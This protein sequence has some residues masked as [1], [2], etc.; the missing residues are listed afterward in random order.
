MDRDI[1][2]Q[3][4]LL[5]LYELAPRQRTIRA[6][7]RFIFY[8]SVTLINIKDAHCNG[9]QEPFDNLPSELNIMRTDKKDDVHRS[10]LFAALA[11]KLPIEAEVRLAL[12]T[13]SLQPAY[14]ELVKI[15]NANQLR[16]QFEL[17]NH[18]LMGE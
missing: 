6:N 16:R 14:L 17:M 12:H 4:P 11:S 9:I 15:K 1:N 7:I 18:A 2:F 3:I 13:H 10:L 5:P 8:A